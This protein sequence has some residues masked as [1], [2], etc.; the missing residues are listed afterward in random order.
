MYCGRIPDFVTKN[1]LVTEINA[2]EMYCKQ[3]EA[4]DNPLEMWHMILDL[5]TGSFTRYLSP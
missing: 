1:I 4:D 3:R 2:K 5:Q